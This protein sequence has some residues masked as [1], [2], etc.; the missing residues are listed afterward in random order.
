M[1]RDYFGKAASIAAVLMIAKGRGAFGQEPPRPP[2]DS[3]L[4]TYHAPRIALVQPAEGGVLP[5]DR[6][7]L[8]IRFAAGEAGDPVDAR[9]FA[10]SVD[11]KDQTSLFQVSA[12]EE[13]GPIAS[14]PSELSLGS[15]EIAARICSARGAC[16]I[17]LATVTVSRS[18]VAAAQTS[19]AK[20]ISKRKRVM[21]AL[22][23]ALRTLIRE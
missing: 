15:H 5:Q 19:S 2:I 9:S 21:D 6:P 12:T 1:A 14:S 7:V 3:S 23:G 20:S 10:V 16:S 8:V 4:L 13:W 17:T 18:M 11:S 22:L